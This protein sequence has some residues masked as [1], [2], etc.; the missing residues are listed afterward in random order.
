[1]SQMGLEPVETGWEEVHRGSDRVAMGAL[2]LEAGSVGVGC[3]PGAF[4]RGWSCVLEARTRG[5]D[6]I[7]SSVG[8]Q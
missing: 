1:M 3:G 5:A 7:P 4:P 6:L 2:I 8:R